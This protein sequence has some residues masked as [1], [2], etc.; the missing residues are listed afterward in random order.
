MRYITLKRN[1]FTLIELLLVIAILGI[2]GA[3]MVPNLAA[4]IGHGEEV[5][6]EAQYT[7]YVMEGG[8]QREIGA[9][10]LGEVL[11]RFPKKMRIG[12][13][14]DVSLNL[15]PSEDAASG[16]SVV[17]SPTDTSVYYMVSD[18]IQL[19]P[20][21][22]AELKGANFTISKGDAN[23]KVVSL[24]STTEW[25][26]IIAP[27]AVGDQ[28]LI[29]ELNAPVRVQE[30]EGLA[31]TAVYKRSLTIAVQKR[32]DWADFLKNVGISVGI[33][34]GLIGIAAAIYKG[35]RHLKGQGRYKPP[36]EV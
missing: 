35:W 12:E 14:G 30:F 15:I 27:I 9:I 3:V 33:I 21:M 7:I 1:G 29:A 6:E 26:W 32:F 25:T 28:L 4:F 36:E 31:T 22:T 8:V 5:I 10:N 24:E 13:S 11:I 2:L 18:M 17:S 23:Y 16:I 19:Y 20:V 34:G